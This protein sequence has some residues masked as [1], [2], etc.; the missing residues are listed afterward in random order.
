MI[1]VLV[2]ASNAPSLRLILASG[3]PFTAYAVAFTGPGVIEPIAPGDAR[4]ADAGLFSR[5]L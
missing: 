1:V 3:A 4:F 2:L 5:S